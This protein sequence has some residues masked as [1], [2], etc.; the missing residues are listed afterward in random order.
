MKLIFMT[1]LELAESFKTMN[2][3]FI[4]VLIVW[5]LHAFRKASNFGNFQQ[6]FHHNAFHQFFFTFFRLTTQLSHFWGG[7]G[8][9]HVLNRDKAQFSENFGYKIDHF[10]KDKNRNKKSFRH[11]TSFLGEKKGPFLVYIFR[12]IF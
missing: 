7:G 11:Y 6:C 2:T 3:I 10:S 1:I 5:K 4:Q 9:L 12:S 8:D